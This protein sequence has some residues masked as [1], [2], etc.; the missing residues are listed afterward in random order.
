M[1]PN[2]V[3]RLLG[4]DQALSLLSRI[5]FFNGFS[6][7][8]MREVER[9]IERRIFGSGEA[10]F[11]QERPG[12]AMYIVLSG[13]VEVV[14]ENDDGKRTELSRVNSGSCFGELALLNDTPQ[15]ATAAATKETKLGVLRRSDF[16]SLVEQRPK[17]GVKILM[18]VSQ[19]VAERLRRTNRALKESRE[20]LAF[21]R[22]ETEETSQ[23][24]LGGE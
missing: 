5:P 9:I 22:Q 20:K 12:V 10:I 23:D 19:I 7:S 4:R 2:L 1:F 11:E 6:R 16:L 14:Q 3:M 21:A 24:E 18:K 15:S 13:E 17:L 8:E